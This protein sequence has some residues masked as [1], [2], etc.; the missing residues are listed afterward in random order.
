M[1]KNKVLS[2]SA[3]FFFYKIYFRKYKYYGFTLK[4]LHLIE[5]VVNHESIYINISIV[6]FLLT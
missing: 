4:K 2:Y 6:P 5:T 1:N 3:T